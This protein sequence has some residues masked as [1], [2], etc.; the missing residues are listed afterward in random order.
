M[1]R[2]E[3]FRSPYDRKLGDLHHL[4][5]MLDKIR[6]MHAG[7]LPDDYHRNYGLSVGLD[8]MLCGF[9]NI[10]FEAVEA[11]VKEGMTDDQIVDWI[12]S[13]GLRPNRSQAQVWNECSRKF[14]WND[15]VS[16]FVAKVKE[17]SGLGSASIC[18]SFD[19][20]E[21]REGREP[22]AKRT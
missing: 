8:G 14:G 3:N 15:R 10:R 13:H 17:E 1:A 18:T 20:I 22:P 4:G 7:N 5:R 11:R 21:L 16:G 12:F 19:L 2:V 6:L 9:L